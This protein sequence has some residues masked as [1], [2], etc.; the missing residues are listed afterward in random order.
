MQICSVRKCGLLYLY[1]RYYVV[2]VADEQA[3]D[4]L[5]VF[6]LLDDEYARAILAALS[7]QPMTA[8]TLS[9]QCKMSLTT[10]YRRLS[11]LEQCGLIVSETVVDADGHHEE[12]YRTEFEELRV[13]LDDGEFQV[14]LSAATLSK[15]FADSFTALWEGL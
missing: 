3:L 2:L 9:D 12:R 14:R 7:H 4:P 5:D 8:T 11:L 6:A 13:R 15:E 1:S 10:V